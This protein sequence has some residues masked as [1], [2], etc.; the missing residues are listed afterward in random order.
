MAQWVG[1]VGWGSGLVPKCP[2]SPHQER[3]LLGAAQGRGSGLAEGLF[4]VCCRATCIDGEAAG[5]AGVGVGG[6]EGKCRY[7]LQTNTLDSTSSSLWHL[8]GAG[9]REEGAR[10]CPQTAGV[11]SLPTGSLLP[12][13]FFSLC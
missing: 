11:T 10:H 6:R 8:L 1:G 7:I 3:H 4:C 13:F 9:S 2:N 5:G 12:Q